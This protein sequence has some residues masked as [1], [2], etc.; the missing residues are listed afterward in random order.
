MS[1]HLNFGAMVLASTDECYIRQSLTPLLDSERISKV[2]VM[3][4][5]K[6]YFNGRIL[7]PDGTEKILDQLARKYPKLEIR[8]R[9]YPNEKLT[10]NLAMEELSEHDKI[11]IFDSDEVVLPKILEKFL[12]WIEQNPF[13]LYSMR[14]KTYW[15]EVQYQIQP[16]YTNVIAV[17]PE[18][19]FDQQRLA[20]G[21]RQTNSPDSFYF[22]HFGYAL[23]PKSMLEK[24][25][26]SNFD[27]LWYENVWEQWVS[28]RKNLN[29][30]SPNAWVEAIKIEPDKDLILFLK[31]FEG[32][33][34]I[35]AKKGSKSRRAFNR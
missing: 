10:R 29:P 3:F 31:E 28:G 26:R 33:K 17:A 7:E 32:R 25:R 19:R 21:W 22:H 35:G 1:R 11:L 8:K 4:S 15:K 20:W 5:E 27:P 13:Q 16:S 12:G 2:L 6:F 34:K 14:C 18:V 9:E 30:Q 23:R 24:C